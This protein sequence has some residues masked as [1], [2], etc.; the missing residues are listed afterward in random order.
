MLAPL[1]SNSPMM[2]Q[3]PWRHATWRAV[4]PPTGLSI[5][6]EQKN[7]NPWLNATKYKFDS[8]SLKKYTFS[9]HCLLTLSYAV[10]FL[11]SY[12]SYY[13]SLRHF[14]SLANTIRKSK[15][16]ERKKGTRSG[17]ASKISL[18]LERLLLL[19]AFTRSMSA[20]QWTNVCVRPVKVWLLQ[21]DN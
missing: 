7:T 10:L 14:F 9:Y 18:T 11:R 4:W 19:A 16:N 13:L 20:Y 12:L 5:C 2:S 21:K 8:R 15:R 3:C 17:L 1:S 6:T